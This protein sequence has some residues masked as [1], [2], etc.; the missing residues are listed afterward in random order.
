MTDTA[1]LDPPTTD[2]PSKPKPQSS[3]PKPSPTLS[4]ATAGMSLPASGLS[5]QLARDRTDIESKT[6]TMPVLQKPPKQD[7]NPDPFLAWGQP[8]M[9]L[10]T[11]GSLFTRQPLTNA[12]NAAAGVMKATNEKDAALAKQK[13]DEW[14]VETDN[15]IKMSEF[16]QK[17]YDAA[18]KKMDV[19][20]K[21]GRAE[22]QAHIDGYK[23]EVLRQTL[24]HE[25]WEGVKK[26]LYYRKQQTAAADESAK[27]L[28]N[29][30]KVQALTD[31]LQAVKT[32]D[33]AMMER[34]KIFAGGLKL[35]STGTLPEE[36]QADKT[37]KEWKQAIDP[38]TNQPYLWRADAH[39]KVEARDMA[40]NE[41]HPEGMA[42]LGAY[43]AP[44][45]TVDAA[46]L[47][48]TS[49]YEGNTH[50]V[51]GLA[52][53]PANM[54]LVQ[55]ELGK[56]IIEKGGSAEEMN[57]N[58]VK[59]AGETAAGRSASVQGER[60]DIGAQELKSQIPKALEASRRVPRFD[61]VPLN[62]LQQA[63]KGQGS[64]PDL[65]DFRTA[66]IGIINAFAQVSARGGAS[67]D[68][69][70]AHA[71]EML[72]TVTSQASYE[73]VLNRLDI[74]AGQ[75]LQGTDA[76]KQK[77]LDEV[78]GRPQKPNI[79]AVLQGIPGLQHNQST[80]MYRDPA[81]GRMWDA[82]GIPVEGQ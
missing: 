70:R 49:F 81:S 45:I 77:N 58:F 23:D 67:T 43:T 16:Q 63:L 54:A 19:D 35:L 4:G 18:I 52:R 37:S 30:F 71:E 24:Q 10:A 48:A 46:K 55:S 29:Q 51:N 34:A 69:A 50:S 12:L 13:Y 41:I 15:A 21:A 39:G 62:R 61:S 80:G 42:K 25:G 44:T 74:E 33:P 27:H 9:L 7:A 3:P 36:N 22:M 64:D 32:G 73:R 53:Q 82:D 38:K 5:D 60:I 47:L 76:A 75:A 68:A 65:A 56:I 20:A 28:E 2:A 8:A 59:F 66:N 78:A 72:A 1:L 26:L 6:P 79:P 40:G 57:A 14:K 31:Y 11:L 17:I